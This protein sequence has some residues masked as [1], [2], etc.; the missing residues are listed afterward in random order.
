MSD[1][2]PHPVAGAKVED[3]VLRLGTPVEPVRYAAAG[4]NEPMAKTMDK[5]DTDDVGQ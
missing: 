5:E 3:I 1:K 4:L 2:L